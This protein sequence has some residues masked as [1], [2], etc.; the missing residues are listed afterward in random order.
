MMRYRERRMPAQSLPLPNKK[1]AHLAPL[2]E[3]RIG[4]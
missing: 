2:F 3:V 1:A 4:K